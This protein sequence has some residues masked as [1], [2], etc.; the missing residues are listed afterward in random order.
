MKHLQLNDDRVKG[1]YV[2][3]VGTDRLLPADNVIVD[4][5]SQR[6]AGHLQTRY[7]LAADSDCR[8]HLQDK[9]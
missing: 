3:V 9:R 4:R 6:L 5:R 2:R 7:A 1:L 8:S